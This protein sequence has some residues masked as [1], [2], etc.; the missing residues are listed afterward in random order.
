[1]LPTPQLLLSLDRPG[2]RYTSYPTVPSWVEDFPQSTLDAALARVDRPADLYVH[3][4]FCR[5]QC[6]FCG[7]NQVVST[8]QGS[9]DRYLDAVA[10]E[11]ASLP[12][13]RAPLPV[14]RIHLGG[15][16]PNWLDAAQ[17]DRLY[18]LLFSRFAPAERAE[19]SVEIDPDLVTKEQLEQ[20]A[21]FGVNRISLG[22]Q[23][24][25]DRVLQAINRPQRLG[26][27]RAAMEWARALGMGGINID[28]IYGLPHQDLA[29]FAAT[30]DEVVALGPDR[31]ATYSYA[32]V[33]WMKRH[34]QH[35]D[36]AALPG[37]VDKMGLFLHARERLIDAGY[38]AVGMDHFAR[39]TDALARAATERTLHRNFMGYTTRADLPLIGL[40]VSAITELDGVFAQAQHHLGTWYRAVERQDGPKLARGLQLTDE[41]RLRRDVISSLMC[42][43][44][45]VKSAIEARHPVSFDA[46]F[47]S[48]LASL[49][50]LVADGLCELH[51][52]RITVT[53]LGR[54]LVRN[55][56]MAFDGRLGDGRFSQTV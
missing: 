6:W 47:A 36:A 5:E 10:T 15:G 27:V 43:F 32:H 17:T 29:S 19:L 23:S 49:E 18:S 22:V 37:P 28:L 38:V 12:L 53:E 8:R 14:A 7:C 20:L 54:L 42:N 21:R 34:Q 31:L 26:R 48:S 30:I 46:H 25:D 40:G 2:P 16:T 33:P 11:I 24:T 39:P 9:G 41:D 45:L 1:M 13:P 51:P 56:A 3:I 52:D 35:I 4:P 44:E 50:P 55:V